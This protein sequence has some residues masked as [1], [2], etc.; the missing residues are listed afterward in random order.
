MRGGHWITVDDLVHLKRG[1]RISPTTALVG[2]TLGIKPLIYI[3]AEGKLDSIG[4]AIT[5]LADRYSENAKHPEGF[6]FITH[7]ECL[8]DAEELA[9]ILKERHGARAQLISGIVPVV[10]AH[11]GPGG[12]ILSFEG[13]QR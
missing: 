4:K 3:N 1:G 11:I 10:G 2:K 12:L 13:R 6:A 9:A 7:S 8:K 5:A